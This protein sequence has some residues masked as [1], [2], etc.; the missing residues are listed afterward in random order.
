MAMMAIIR[1]V[2]GRGERMHKQARG[3]KD[4]HLLSMLLQFWAGGVGQR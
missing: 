3:K 4:T 2:R 1:P